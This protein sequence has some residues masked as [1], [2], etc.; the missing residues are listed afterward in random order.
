VYRQTGGRRITG[1]RL[2]ARFAGR[3]APFNWSGRANVR[4]GRV[5]NGYYVAAM[6]V[7]VG[8]STDLRQQAF[9]RRNGHFKALP[10]FSSKRTCAVVRAFT[11]NKP[12]FG[13]SNNR[14]LSVYYEL[15]RTARVAVAFSRGKRVV[16]RVRARTQSPGSYRLGLTSRGLRRGNYKVTLTVVQGGRTSRVHLT[17]RRL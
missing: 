4:R 8:R 11:L 7:P 3:T 16:R 9:I 17:A 15:H 14:P 12:V 6:R 1:S 10:A 5:T 13:G 2:V